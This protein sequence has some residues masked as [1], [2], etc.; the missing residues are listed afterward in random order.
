MTDLRTFLEKIRTERKADLVEVEREVSP[1]YESAAIV[2]K[3]EEQKRSPILYYKNVRGSRLPLVTNVCGSMGR[4]ALALEVPLKSV[5]ERYGQAVEAPIPPVIIAGPA[6]VQENIWTGE[7][8]DLGILP[9][10]V[11]HQDDSPNPYITAAIAVARDPENGHVNLSYHRLMIASKNTT[12]I[13]MERGK[14]L[15]AIY[16]KYVALG[17]DMP[18]A[19]FIG[20][21]PLWS[22]GALYSGPLSEYDVIGG[23]LKTPLP[24]VECVTQKGIFVP[25]HAEL[26]LE[27]TVAHDRMIEEGPFGEFTGY[28][29][30]RTETPPFTVTAMTFRNELIFQDVVSGHMEHLLLSVP[31]IEYR[32]LK[33]ARSV[34]PNVAWVNNP[35]PLTTVVGLKKTDDAEPKKILDKLIRADIYAKHV[36]IVDA[37]VSAGELREVVAA[38]ALNVQATKNL[39]IYPD[40]QGTP[41]DPSCPTN[42]GRGAK[43][44]IDA[45]TPIEPPRPVTK[46]RIPQAVLDA[47]DLSAIL[48]RRGA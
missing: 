34:S 30:G 14:H 24:L 16:Q 28:G 31:A 45:T 43:M 10:L 38:I 13:L 12:G 6:P 41:L 5:G 26:V 33:D 18:V 22:L 46:N 11:Y 25:S 7:Q 29:T 4:L 17:R 15:D 42:S 37:G 1:R 23:L 35:A 47:I 3:L 36:I 27:G 40:E 44:G 21:H 2:V 32:T 9:A 8:V 19:I 39:Y 48:P 20:A